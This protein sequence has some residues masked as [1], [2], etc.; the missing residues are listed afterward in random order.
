MNTAMIILMLSI[1][2]ITLAD[3]VLSLKRGRMQSHLYVVDRR[4]MPYRF[5]YCI[6]SEVVFSFAFF[7]M[8]LF[9][10]YDLPR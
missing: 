1:G 10:L 8:G 3:A 7:A 5:Y 4:S 9:M 2:F 6:V